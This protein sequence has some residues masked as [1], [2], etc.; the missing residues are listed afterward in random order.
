M[1]L[2][3]GLR[4][5]LLSRSVSITFSFKLEFHSSGWFYP[6]RGCSFLSSTKCC[7]G[8]LGSKLTLMSYSMAV[9]SAVISSNWFDLTNSFHQTV[10]GS[11]LY[12]LLAPTFGRL[13]QTLSNCQGN[14]TPDT[15]K[16]IL[17]FSMAQDQLVVSQM[18]ICYSLGF[19]PLVNPLKTEL[20]PSK[21]C[22]LPEFFY[23]G[24]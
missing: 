10:L 1:Q 8:S 9:D 24:F 20:N 21:H 5:A 7:M 18:L 3:G 17:Y 15:R 12:I 23:W 11:L 16:F 19:N 6:C 22:C 14:P 2:L 13:N 4:G